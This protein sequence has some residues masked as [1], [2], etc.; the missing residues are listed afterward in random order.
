VVTVPGVDAATDLLAVSRSGIAA[1]VALRSVGPDEL[2]AAWR[3]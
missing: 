1:D 2:M 3:N